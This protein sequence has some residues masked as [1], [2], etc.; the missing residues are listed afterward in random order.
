MLTR[1]SL[2]DDDT[3]FMARGPVSLRPA[4]AGLC[5]R[6]ANGGPTRGRWDGG[7]VM[8]DSAVVWLGR[9]AFGVA[10]GIESV[11]TGSNCLANRQSRRDLQR[12]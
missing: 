5:S 10:V 1:S 9:S 7:E 12:F 2:W 11:R 6:V 3:C 4:P 8:M